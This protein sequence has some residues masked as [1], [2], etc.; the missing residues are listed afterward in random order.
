MSQL[1]SQATFSDMSGPIMGIMTLLF[2][3]FFFGWAAWAYAPANRGAM[4]AA[5]RLPL[6]DDQSAARGGEA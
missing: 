3:L 5:A 6:D 4:R 2:L 1:V